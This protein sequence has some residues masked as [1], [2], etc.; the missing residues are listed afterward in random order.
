[1][2]QTGEYAA[3]KIE[4]EITKVTDAIFDVVAEDKKKKHFCVVSCSLSQ[5]ERGVTPS[6][7]FG[8]SFGKCEISGGEIAAHFFRRAENARLRVV[9]LVFPTR[10]DHRRQTIAEH[11]D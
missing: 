3:N 9:E 6:I 4:D 7:P 1:M 11:V 5:R 10:D 2:R 8:R